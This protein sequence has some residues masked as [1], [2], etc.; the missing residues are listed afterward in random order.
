ME[1]EFTK[2]VVEESYFVGEKYP[3]KKPV[4]NLTSEG[5]FYVPEKLA[6]GLPD[7]YPMKKPQDNLKP[8]GDF[9]QRPKGEIPKGE[10]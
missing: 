9:A 5:E 8:E 6:P 1:G 4:D 2:R 7:R 3:T 10:R